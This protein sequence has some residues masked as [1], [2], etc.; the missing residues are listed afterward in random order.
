[1][2]C[3][4]RTRQTRKFIVFAPDRIDKV[5]THKID[6]IRGD[7]IEKESIFGSTTVNL[8]AEIDREG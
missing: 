1:M 2:G 6:K 7:K 5:A 4:T 8:R 3:I